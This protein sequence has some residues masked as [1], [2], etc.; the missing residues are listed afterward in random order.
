MMFNLL[1]QTINKP[2]IFE[3]VALHSGKSVK[4]TL[5]PAE[6]DVGII[7][8]RV[9]LKKNNMIKAD[10]KNVSSATLC[11]TLENEFKNKVSTVE[12]LLAALYIKGID[13][14]IIQIN[15]DEVP[16]MDGSSKDFLEALNSIEMRVLKTK[17]RFLK[18][19]ERFSFCDNEKII[20]VEPSDSFIVD[21]ELNYENKIIGNQRNFVNFSNDSLDEVINSRTFCLFKD[22]EYIK[23]L[24]L[25][26]GGSLA[27]AVVVDDE[28]VLNKEGLRNQKEFVNHK[29]LDL[30]GDFILSGFSFL[31]KV[32]C[33]KGGHQLSNLFLRELL[34]NN[35]DKFEIIEFELNKK[36]TSTS[37]NYPSQ[38][39]VNA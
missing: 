3:G 16:I 15:G 26:K 25:A 19:L 18:I 28:K 6:E 21:F 24:G 37:E 30:A 8:K 12:H 31:G 22:I 10:Y 23:K 14:V 36:R 27:N 38:I 33:T 9:D 13:N 35:S 5:L 7:F 32:K 11:T 29:I 20:N 17:K 1:Q 2:L 39:A 34:D 4:M